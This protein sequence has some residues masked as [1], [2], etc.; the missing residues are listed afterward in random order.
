MSFYFPSS[1][2]LIA[3]KQLNSPSFEFENYITSQKHDELVS[4]RASDNRCFP[5]IYIKWS[6]ALCGNPRKLDRNIVS[7]TFFIVLCH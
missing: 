6:A 4:A 3:R 7:Q 2:F 5:R 1:I